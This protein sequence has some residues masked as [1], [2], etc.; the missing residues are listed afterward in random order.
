MDLLKKAKKGDRDAF[1]DLLTQYQ[2][3]LYNTA[4]LILRN[5]DD[6]LDAVQ[7]ALLACWEKLPGLRQEKYFKTWLTR[8][9][10]NKCYDCLRA[11]SHFAD[12]DLLP[13]EG[14]TPDWDTVLD[15]DRA[16]SKL[17]QMDRLL[18]SLFYYDGFTTKEIARALS[19]S[20]GAVRTRLNRSRNR[21][22]T[23]FLK[24]DHEA[25]E[26]CGNR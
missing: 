24:E 18:L 1:A 21:L 17:S 19:M 12:G 26:T 16:M 13:E 7:D 11:R 5:E 4:L 9:L 8:I 25:Y 23:A 3:M 20:D 22:K 2:T 6:A 10:M 15:V 14:E